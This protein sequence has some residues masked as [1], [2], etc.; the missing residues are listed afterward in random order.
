M[1]ELFW[2]HLESGKT[3]D[4]QMRKPTKWKL[5]MKYNLT[6]NPWHVT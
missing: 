1:C 5:H 2:T 4:L 6:T 3:A